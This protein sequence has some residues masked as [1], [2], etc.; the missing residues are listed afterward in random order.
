MEKNN[1][2][3]FLRYFLVFILVFALAFILL[4]GTFSKDN[5]LTFLMMGID[6]NSFKENSSVRSDTIMLINANKKSGEISIVSIPRDT[7]TSIEGRKNEEKVNHSFAYGGPELALSTVSNLLGLDIEYYMVV[8]Y[9]VVKEYVDLIGGIDYYVPMDMKYSDPVADPPLLIDLKEG[10]QILDGDKT[11]QYLRFR[12][13]YKDADLG[14]INAQQEFLKELI[15]QSISIKNIFKVPGMISIYSNNVTTNIPMSKF[16]QY[17]LSAFK[18][19]LSIL[20]N[21]TLP[22]SP[23]T[24]GG[25]SYFIHSDEDMEILMKEIFKDY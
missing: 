11:L 1:K 2:K 22:G 7:K 10:Q 4:S 18:Y 8:D 3:I 14:R 16:I 15:S 19:D 20:R 17:G 9:Q 25:V 21:E 13:G 23:K 12:K 24:I 5:N 6:S